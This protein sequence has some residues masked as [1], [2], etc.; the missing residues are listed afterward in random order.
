M[1]VYVCDR[2]S[3]CMSVCEREYVIVCVCVCVCVSMCVCMCVCVCEYVLTVSAQC[4]RQHLD[5]LVPDGVPR[6]QVGGQPP[7]RGA[8]GRGERGGGGGGRLWG[9]CFPLNTHTAEHQ[10]HREHT[11]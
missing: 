9:V 8:E 5:A 7:P 3:V 1:S 2:E 4:S 11:H 10:R 6:E